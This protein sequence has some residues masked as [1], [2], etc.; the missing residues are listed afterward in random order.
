MTRAPKLYQKLARRRG[1]LGTHV[2]LWLAHDHV[3][4]V[5]GT[6]FTESYQ[7]V[8]LRDVQGLFIRPSR[9][10]KWV[11]FTSLGFILLFGGLMALGGDLLPVFGVLGGLAVIVL[12][13]GLFFA[14]SCHFHV[15]T[16]VQRREWPNVARYR[17]ARKVIARLSPLIRETQANSGVPVPGMPP[18]P[19]S[20]VSIEA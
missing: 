18:L 5:E 11:T 2:S 13:Y 7:R 3:L 14:R 1:G 15:L 12:L 6:S 4:L 16:A 9:E 8:Y 19:G 20:A 17:Q 10:S